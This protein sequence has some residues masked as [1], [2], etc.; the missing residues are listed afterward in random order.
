MPAL[1]KVIAV[2]D[3][4]ELKT[5]LQNIRHK[6]ERLEPNLLHA[7]E[8]VPYEN[9]TSTLE[10]IQTIDSFPPVVLAIGMVQ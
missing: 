10:I 9:V 8:D 4:A 5:Y 1:R 3:K 7:A 2:K 6:Y